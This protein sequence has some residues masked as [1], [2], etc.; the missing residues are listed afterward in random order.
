MK[1]RIKEN[2]WIARVAARK[3]KADKVAIVVGNTIHLHNT[4]RSGFLT[5]KKWMAHEL[6]H[7]EQYRQHG[8]LGFVFKYLIESARK[9]YYNNRFEVEARES[10]EDA[11]LIN[12]I[13]IV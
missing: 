8:Y 12:Q 9:G 7:V 13:E 11:N 1:V 2:S 3:L 10:E 6:K 4:S 5:D